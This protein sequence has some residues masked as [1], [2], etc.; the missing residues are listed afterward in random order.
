MVGCAEEADGPGIV[1]VGTGIN[2]ESLD[3]QGEADV[4]VPD[5][6]GLLPDDIYS[7]DAVEPVDVVQRIPTD[8]ESQEDGFDAVPEE[9]VFDGGGL[10]DVVEP[11]VNSVDAGG[12]APED[13]METGPY[14][15]IQG[16]ASI[17]G[18]GGF[19]GGSDIP[20]DLYL[21]SPQ[22][23]FPVIVFLHGFSLSP[24]DYA[25]YGEHLASWG[26]VAVLPEMPGS[27]VTPAT[28]VDLKEHLSSILDWVESNPN[29][30]QGKANSEQMGLAGHS[31]G[32]KISL[33]LAT[34]DDRPKAIC[35]VDPVDSGPPISFNSQ[36]YP[37]VTPELM[38]QISVPLL[39]LGETVDGGGSAQPCAPAD[40]NFQQY[41]AAAV[42]PVLE[43]EFLGA[44]HM[45][46]LD[47]PDCGLTCGFCQAGTADPVV[48]RKLAQRLL[49]AFFNQ[50]L[51]GD[52]E[53][54]YWLTGAGMQGSVDDGLRLWQT[55]N[56]FE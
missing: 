7:E 44:N 53:A 15:V 1:V 49:V 31:M 35:G 18:S 8:V 19:F 34:E 55:Q 10:I 17:G 38:D 20:L 3:A 23:P 42:S 16:S 25:S 29:A 26:Y 11:D 50:R 48:T 28:H 30:L 13:P 4:N 36:N 14:P 54:S 32:G 9:D 6:V 56:C 22:G 40:D 37:S 5:D 39:L 43:V 52:E 45:A 24:G 51:L 27:L 46:F 2:G 21:P 41:Y 47:N 33:F 12:D